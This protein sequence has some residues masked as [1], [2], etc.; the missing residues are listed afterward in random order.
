MVISVK[1]LFRKPCEFVAGAA[2]EDRLPKPILPEVAFVGRSNVG[3]SSLVNA[4]LRRK[5]LARVSKT[6]GCTQQINFFQLAED[7]MIVDLPGYGYAKASA[8]EVE[9]WGQLIILYLTGRPNLKRVMLLI[10]ARRGIKDADI[11]IMTILDEAAVSYQIVLTKRDKITANDEAALRV[12]I[13]N[14]QVKHTALHPEILVTSTVK[15]QGLDEVRS[16][17]ASFV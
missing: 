11:Q 9:G 16:L 10:D 2:T 12:D 13:E 4:I 14:L 7:L 3:K 17:L 6:P 5:A 8:R 1:T 15:M